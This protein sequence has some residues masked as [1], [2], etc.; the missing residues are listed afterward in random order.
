MPPADARAGEEE[1]GVKMVAA[2]RARAVARRGRGKVVIIS[3]I[4][5]DIFI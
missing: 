2:T 1:S 3:W 5:R 4:I